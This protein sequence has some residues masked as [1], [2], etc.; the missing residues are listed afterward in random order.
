MNLAQF[1][2]TLSAGTPPVHTTR[3]LQALWYD[4]IGDWPTAHAHA[5]AQD[6]PFGAWVHAYLHRKEGDMTNARYWYC[7]AGRPV[8]TLALAAE[9]DAIASALLARTD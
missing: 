2:A 6:D 9:W 3:A 7:R 8:A 1:K 5:Q 4:A